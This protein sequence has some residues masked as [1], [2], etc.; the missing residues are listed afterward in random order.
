MRTT[1]ALAPMVQIEDCVSEQP[2]TLDIATRLETLEEA[3]K[4]VADLLND[5]P[6]L[7][8][9]ITPEDNVDLDDLN[10]SL[11][12]V[13]DFLGDD[14]VG[15]TYTHAP[16]EL[17]GR[18][19]VNETFIS[20]VMTTANSIR[21]YII[22]QE[23]LELLDFDTRTLKRDL[24][25]ALD[26][27]ERRQFAFL[28][29]PQQEELEKFAKSIRERLR[30]LN[31]DYDLRSATRRAKE[32]AASAEESASKASS[33]AGMTAD[34]AMSSFYEKLGTDEQSTAD[35]FRRWAIA[36]GSV[37]GVMAWIFLSGGAGWGAAWLDIAAGDYVHL[38]QRGLVLAAFLAL[39]TYLAR[40]AHQ[41]R[42]M[43]NWARSLAV[44]LKTFDAFIDPIDDPAVRD[45]LRKNFASRVFG[46]H[47]PVKG[48]PA[49]SA[50]SQ[51]ISSLTEALSKLIPAGK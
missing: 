18:Q 24:E 48:E 9:L 49:I 17:R 42:T 34:S 39:A 27:A 28:T 2:F 13:H 41:H 14:I 1:T 51:G 5:L 47:P 3:R 12:L 6:E 19:P 8:K 33:A 7:T 21:R 31:G 45:E 50:S 23:L 32:A 11:I 15:R 40:Q 4:A 44:Q 16:V 10:G 35:L 29:V 25:D 43:A 20:N 38:I 22:G 30:K 37:A 36:L 46:D 26:R